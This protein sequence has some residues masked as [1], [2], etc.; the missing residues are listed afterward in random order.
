LANS[1]FFGTNESEATICP[2][3]V[4]GK[5]ISFLD[6]IQLMAIRELRQKKNV[7]LEKVRQLLSVA[8]ANGIDHPFAKKGI[9][10]RWHNELGLALPD[11]RLIE[12]SGQHRGSTYLKEIVMV[13]KEDLSYDSDG[14]ANLYR[15]WHWDGCTVDMNPSVRF[16]EPM[17]MSC[18]YSAESLW[19]AATDEG[20][21]EGA[22]RVY[23]VEKKEVE[24]ACRYFDMLQ[25]KAA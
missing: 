16:G 23:G 10:F 25:G 4:D 11:G 17:L 7:K 13:Y 6:F 21:V 9:T 2:Q 5:F 3:M 14:V 20:S 19:E 8:R 18:G 15:A 1:W 12:A 24:T 22:A